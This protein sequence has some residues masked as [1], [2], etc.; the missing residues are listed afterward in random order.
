LQAALLIIHVMQTFDLV[1]SN[2]WQ[3]CCDWHYPYVID[4][5]IM[6][7]SNSSRTHSQLMALCFLNIRFICQSHARELQNH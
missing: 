5:I 6:Y 3:K 4:K 7:Q 1:G 2:H